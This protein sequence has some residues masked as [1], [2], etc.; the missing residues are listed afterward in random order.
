MPRLV[1]CNWCHSLTRIPDVLKGTP[2]V[3]AMLEWKDGERFIYRDEQGLPTMVPAYDPILEDFIETHTHGLRDDQVIGGLIEVYAVDQKTWDAM[4]VVTKIQTE[5]QKQ[6]NQHY[7]EVDE[8]KEAAVKCYNAHGN[9]DLSSGCP[10]YLDD[11]KRIGHASYTDDDGR[12]I[13]VPPKFRQYLCYLCPYQQT[14]IQV[15]LRRRR[16]A[17]KQ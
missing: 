8:Y 5:L 7:A 2:M 1:A 11:S 15:E 13:T 6:T 9:P 12:T 16:G 10:D 4:D 14:Y 3:P 17:Y